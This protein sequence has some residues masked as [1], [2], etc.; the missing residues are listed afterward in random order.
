MDDHPLLA[1]SPVASSSGSFPLLPTDFRRLV[2]L[3]DRKM[4]PARSPSSCSSS[5]ISSLGTVASAIAASDFQDG[6]VHDFHAQLEKLGDILGVARVLRVDLEQGLSADDTDGNLARRAE[7]FGV[8]Y[9]APPPARGLL[10]LMAEAVFMDTTNLI[11]VIDGVVA[12]ALGMAVGGH[13]ST[14]W[15]EGTCVLIAVLAIV[16]AV[17]DF[18]K[19][20]Q[21]ESERS[22]NSG[23]SHVRKWSLVVGDIVQLEPGDVV[24]AYGLAFNTRE[25][26]LHTGQWNLNSSH[27]KMHLRW[28]V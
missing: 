25:L 22:D 10:R 7:W 17:G 18:Q 9:V 24:P 14:D 27:W 16:T 26:K 11:L 15:M 5:S 3:P 1:L 19:E 20:R 8:N 21:Q 28:N 13:P 23:D 12:V 6:E 4:P 2:A